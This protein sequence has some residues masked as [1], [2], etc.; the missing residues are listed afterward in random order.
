MTS[1]DTARWPLVQGHLAFISSLAAC[2]L[3]G[4]S[5]LQQKCGKTSSVVNCCTSLH[6][7]GA[8]LLLLLLTHSLAALQPLRPCLRSAGSGA[9]SG[10]HAPSINLAVSPAFPFFLRLQELLALWWF[11]LPWATQ[12]V[13][14]AHRCGRCRQPPSRPCPALRSS[15]GH[16][17]WRT[18]EK[19]EG[20]EGSVEKSRK[21]FMRRLWEAR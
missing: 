18:R 2:T 5:F 14:L 16:D 13:G 6:A 11:F 9:P 7:H 17:G 20:S 21:L 3:P 15:I 10:L 19:Y 4:L 8:G 12:W 1:P